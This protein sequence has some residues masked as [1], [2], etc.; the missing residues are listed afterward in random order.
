M[1]TAIHF[2]TSTAAVG[3][4]LALSP[5]VTFAEP[6]ATADQAATGDPQAGVA[7]A[8]AAKPKSPTD[9]AKTAASPTPARPKPSFV[10]VPI[11]L[12]NPAVGSGVT[13][14]G[15]A[16]YKPRGSGAVWT[17]GVGGLYTSTK[18]YAIGVLQKS[19]FAGDRFRLTAAA[20]YGAFNL[21]FY[22][23]GALAQANRYIEINQ[24]GS[25]AYIEGLMRVAPH[26]YVGPVYR[27]I[28]LK[29]TLPPIEAFGITIPLPQLKSVSSALGGSALYDSRDSQYGPS[30]GLYAI[31][32]WIFAAPALGS[33][34]A[35]GAPLEYN[36]ATVA[37]NAYFPLAKS[38]VLA[39]RISACATSQGA[40]FYDICLYGMSNDLRGYATGQYRDP[41]M[42]TAQVELRQ[43]LFWRLGAVA[44]AGVGGIAPGP[45]SLGK[46]FNL[47][48]ALFLPAGGVGLRIMASPQYKVNLGI[49]YAVGKNSNGLYI[50][51]GEA[52]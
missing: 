36:R 41:R 10:G 4:A 18:S 47:G 37:V 51:L 28:D 31:A 14:V 32:Q 17:S 19:S 23:V 35:L 15:M 5:A 45:N 22:G 9:S 49:D 38:T 6:A 8:P 33:A 40:P 2:W 7:A 27:L 21:R 39:A 11:P 12:S 30:R 44:F 3:L 25:V 26:T 29:T 16:L 1:R 46:N 24:R 42:A 52:F 20:G 34:N 48:N 50:R 13:L 43:H